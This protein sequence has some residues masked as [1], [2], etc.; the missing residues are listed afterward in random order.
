MIKYIKGDVTKADFS[1]LV[2]GCN[3]QGKMASG[4]AKCIADKW[5]IVKQSY[6]EWHMDC[7]VSSFYN[8][9]RSMLGEL[10]FVLIDSPCKYVVNAITQ[11]YY[12][13][14]GEK[15]VS[16]DAI[17]RCMKELN[18]RIMHEREGLKPK[19]VMPKIGSERGGGDWNVIEKIIESH[20][21]EHDVTI[22]YL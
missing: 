22:Y 18:Y 3:A 12:G 6:E 4:V 2:H 14:D 21:S 11:Q 13:Y 17:D 19:I 20:L 16:Y 1:I 15:Y 9:S 10:Q 8:D 5:P 7:L